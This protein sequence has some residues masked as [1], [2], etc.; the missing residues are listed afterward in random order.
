MWTRH[1]DKGKKSEE[2]KAEERW[3][4]S[5]RRSTAMRRRRRR[6]KGKVQKSGCEDEERKKM[7]EV[8]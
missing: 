8:S 6:L 4:S 5:S 7:P 1:A 3:T 2:I